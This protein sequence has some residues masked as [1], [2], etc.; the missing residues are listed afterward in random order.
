MIKFIFDP[1]EESS[2]LAYDSLHC[3][4]GLTLPLGDA[5]FFFHQC[6]QLVWVSEEEKSNVISLAAKPSA[7]VTQCGRREKRTMNHSFVDGRCESQ[8]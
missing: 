3:V 4:P 8:R 5:N 1:R 7:T 2:G 6:A